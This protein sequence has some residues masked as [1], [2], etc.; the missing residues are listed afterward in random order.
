[1]KELFLRLLA[2]LYLSIK[3]LFRTGIPLI[4]VVILCVL[5]WAATYFITHNS[6]MDRI[7]GDTE[8]D[9]AMRYIEIKN[10]IDEHYID[11]VN[12]AVMADDAAAAMVAGLGDPWSYFLTADEYRTYQLSSANDYADIGMSIVKDDSGGGFQVISVYP[13]SP[14]ARAGVMNGMVIIAVD[15]ESLDGYTTD[16][17]RTLI[18]S[19]LN[20]KFILDFNNGTRIEVDCSTV[21]EGSVTFRLEKTGAAYIQIH[22][23]EAGSGQAAVDAIEYLLKQGAVSLVI[24]LRN[25]PG[26]LSSEAAILLD[27][28]LPAGRLF[29]EVDK[30]GT[31][32]VTESDSMNLQMPTCVLIN[33]GTF[34]EAE[35]FAAVLKE[36]GWA[37]LMGEPTTGNTRTQETIPLSD[38]SAIRLST[39]S[40]LTPSGVDLCAAG[41]VVPDFIV[42]N[43]D[44]SATGT[45]QGTTGGEDGTA[46]ISNDEQLMAALRLLS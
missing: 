16:A 3:K 26:G 11:P 12:R 24:D 39:K 1:V 7:G 18:R 19:K 32:S 42:F 28:L 37:T 14:A 20:T 22:N 8:Y 36:W 21:N 4:V 25:N 10:V 6:I 23:F 46:S 33:S 2:K 38:G 15:G 30:K 27:Y 35:L 43:S 40:Y 45:T 9:E 13:D 41:G 44:E 17:V 34:R 5:V 31:V 29:S